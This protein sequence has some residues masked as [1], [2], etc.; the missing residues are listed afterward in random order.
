MQ[1]F[2]VPLVI[3]VVIVMVCLMFNWLAH[4]GSQPQDLVADL[5]KLNA[6]SWQKA[7]TVANMLTD[8]R[9]DELRR[10]REMAKRL[11]QILAQQLEAGDALPERIKLRIYL[12]VALGVFEVDEGLP[13]LIDA[14][15]LQRDLA[16]IEVRKSAI[17]AIARRADQSPERQQQFQQNSELLA[18]LNDA[19][20]QHSG[21]PD[22]RELDAQLRLR[23]AYALGVI[24]GDSAKQ[25]LAGLLADAEPS[26]RYNAATGLARHGDPR[27]VPRLVEMLAVRSSGSSAPNAPDEIETTT[28]L[29]NALRAT[30]QLAEANPSVD[31]RPLRAAISELDADEQLSRTVRRGIELDVRTALQRL[32]PL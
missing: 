14:A 15:R 2:V 20:G 22:Q 29:Q 21:Q 28:I 23:A 5:A 12:C 3:V 31:L 4:L 26:V 13:E 17:E 32:A 16:D 19:A 6:G 9:N 1:L 25:T 11:A 10:D 30:V 24:G 27:A 18:V 8:R 7:L